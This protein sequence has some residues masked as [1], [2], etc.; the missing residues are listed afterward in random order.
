MLDRYQVL[1]VLVTNTLL[2]VILLN[3]I[4]GLYYSVRLASGAAEHGET[5]TPDPILKYGYE[6]LQLAY[7]GWTEDDLSALLGEVWGR[8]FQC[9][10]FVHF[11]EIPVDGTYLHVDEAGFR[12]NAEA[13]PWPPVEDALTIF[14]FG[15]STT[16]GYGLP[17][18]QTI[19]AAM[20]EALQQTSEGQAI[21]VYNFGQ[22]AYYSALEV[23]F[24]QELLRA[25]HVPDVV[26]FIDGLN[27]MGNRIE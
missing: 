26:I 3:L 9:A 14:V 23:T 17:D 10:P 19:P 11:R 8:R 18:Y 13:P 6:T 24:F 12:W 1:S 7:P 5:D 15:G 21:H 2:L 16:F 22:G 25:G 20:Q 27:D 4:L